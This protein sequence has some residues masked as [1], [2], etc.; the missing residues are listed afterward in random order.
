M[1]SIP[2]AV[3]SLLQAQFAHENANYFRYT[4][5]STWASFSGL[6]GAAAFFSH[7][8][9]DE[10]D[11]AKI[12]RKYIESRNESVICAPF[13]FDEDGNIATFDELFTSALEV[14]RATT[15]GIEEIYAEAYNVGDFMTCEWVG[16]MLAIQVEE[17]NTYQEIID[18]IVQRGGGQGQ[19]LSLTVFR[20]DPAAVHDLD[21]WIGKHY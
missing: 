11:H 12:V 21:V 18:R 6:K 17:E 8:A 16:K 9:N 13:A 3:L 7:E 15:A 14:E 1:G 10:L 5:R 2:A 4:A 19:D 20:S